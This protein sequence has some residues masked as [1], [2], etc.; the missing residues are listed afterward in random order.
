LVKIEHL[1]ALPKDKLYVQPT[2]GMKPFIID[3]CNY[4]MVP[5]M[6]RRSMIPPPRMSDR[7]P[8]DIIRPGNAE[9]EAERE[10]A[11]RAQ[12]TDSELQPVDT[13]R[14]PAVPA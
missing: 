8:T 5:E 12:F 2:D 6:H 7:L 3:K 14:G 1:A 4:D 13:S 9:R 11:L 10:A